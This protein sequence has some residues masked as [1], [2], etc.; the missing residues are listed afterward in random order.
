[1]YGFYPD[2]I[3]NNLTNRYLAVVIGT[4]GIIATNFKSNAGRFA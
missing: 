1:M 4:V 2:L 3:V